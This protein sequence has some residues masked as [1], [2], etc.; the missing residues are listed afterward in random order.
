MLGCFFGF[1]TTLRCSRPIVSHGFV[2][3][4]RTKRECVIDLVSLNDI[5]LFLCVCLCILVLPCVGWGCP[6]WAG[7]GWEIFPNEEWTADWP[8][9]RSLEGENERENGAVCERNMEI[10]DPLNVN[11]CFL[12]SSS[13]P[14]F[15]PQL[16]SIHMN[17]AEEEE[18][19]RG[20]R[21]ERNRAVKS[22]VKIQILP[23][24]ISVK[25]ANQTWTSICAPDNYNMFKASSAWLEV[26]TQHQAVLISIHIL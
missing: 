15:H 1:L 23:L 21:R 3:F 19:K 22:T 4:L 18:S 6:G 25:Q 5:W 20:S 10:D 16:L 11:A 9:S 2:I 13:S 8:A 17:E 14:H 24:K 12:V 7:R 26:N